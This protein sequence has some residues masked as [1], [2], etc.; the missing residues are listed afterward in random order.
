M[1]LEQW[2]TRGFDKSIVRCIRSW[3]QDTCLKPSSFKERTFLLL[4]FGNV[5][6][7]S[8]D[9]S[10]HTYL[11]RND[12]NAGP[13]RIERIHPIVRVHP[14]TGYKSLY[15][16]R[17]MTKSIVGLDKA[18]S[19]LI[20]NYLYDV[21]ERNVDIQVGW[22]YFLIIH[23]IPSFVMFNADS[24]T[25]CALNGVSYLSI[26]NSNSPTLGSWD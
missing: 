15:V 9:V 8:G 18:E 21:Y 14:A 1:F 11:D 10:A 5:S 3:Q 24:E 22:Y 26:L 20:L 16:N 19:D 13:K 2:E 17:A 23:P 4:K 25:R 7:Q 12:P 6:W